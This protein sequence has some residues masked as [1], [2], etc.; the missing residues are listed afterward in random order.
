MTCSNEAKW[1]GFNRYGD[2]FDTIDCSDPFADKHF[3]LAGALWERKKAHFRTAQ[4]L[5]LACDLIITPNH[6]YLDQCLPEHAAVKGERIF[7]QLVCPS[8]PAGREIILQNYE[9]L[10]EDLAKTGVRLSGL[11]AC[12]YDYGGCACEACKPWILTFAQLTRDIHQIAEKH[13]PG[14]EMHFVGW[15]WAEEE[16]RQ[17]AEWVD[18]EAPGWAKSIALHIPYGKTDVSDVVL[19]AGCERRA[20]VHIGYGEEASPKD[21]Y[22]HLGPV[23]AASRIE[24]TV[25]DLSERGCTGVMAYSEGVFDDINKAI[26]AGLST[27]I[28]DSSTQALRTYA[29]RY[30]DA[31]EEENGRG[32]GGLVA[33]AGQTFR[34]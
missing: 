22:G 26:L 11:S 6:V 29:E 13:H 19:P 10:F 21:T 24:K 3:N 7:G 31:S 32:M 8:K 20:F 34:H 33:G 2:W 14:I 16:H 23:V 15:W 27:G 12:P 9:N 18:R 28:L 17:F 30:L 25:K 1:W 4:S 5:G